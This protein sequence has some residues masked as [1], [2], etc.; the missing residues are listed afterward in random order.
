MK[1][2]EKIL[3]AIFK[4]PTGMGAADLIIEFFKGKAIHVP[5]IG[6]YVYSGTHWIPD[7]AEVEI[8]DLYRE[9]LYYV[10][11]SDD[12]KTFYEKKLDKI[13][14]EDKRKACEK[15]ITTFIRS[16]GNVTFKDKVLSQVAKDRR[17]HCDASKLNPARNVLYFKNG[18]LD[19]NTKKLSVHRSENYNTYVYDW[20]Y[21]SNATCPTFLNA[22][23][24]M[25]FDD[26]DPEQG[27][28]ELQAYLREMIGF[29]LLRKKPDQKAFFWDGR[30]GNGKSELVRVLQKVAGENAAL[31]QISLFT[32]VE[33]RNSNS[34]QSHL[35]PLMGKSVVIA[36]EGDDGGQLNDGIFKQIT[37][38]D[39]I[40]A[41]AAYSAKTVN[42]RPE[43]AAVIATNAL[44]T[45]NGEDEA[46]RRRV[47]RIN[48]P[49][50]FVHEN[51][52]EEKKKTHRF[53]KVKK[54]NIRKDLEDELPGIMAWAIEGAHRVLHNHGISEPAI[55]R[56]WTD[57]YFGDEDPVGAFIENQLDIDVPEYL[58][59]K[60]S[61]V[62]EAF[63]K[64]YPESGFAKR[65]TEKRFHQVLKKA[66]FDRRA[67][68]SGRILYKGLTLK[69][70]QKKQAVLD[71]R[72]R[73]TDRLSIDERIIKIEQ[74]AQT[75]CGNKVSVLKWINSPQPELGGSSPQEA[76]QDQKLFE[77]LLVA[78]APHSTSFAT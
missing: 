34:H 69:D 29:C 36:A 39:Q 54:A 70:T 63:S 50:R 11:L 43:L 40:S 47:H 32:G 4:D 75:V 73:N 21:D 20:D 67:N 65:V 49:C 53:V 26:R 7:I 2:Y 58:T 15:T 16:L 3:N 78:F 59:M 33:A 51:E 57:Q 74:I 17:I 77:K 60:A 68:H 19:L 18:V 37:G 46:I 13:E 25:V 55:I 62:Y 41:R 42:F 14:E 28:D 44:P 64:W 12:F 24:D 71:I 76:I 9:A 27:K 56:Y 23:S 66:L 38:G 45:I 35:I 8:Y 61:E 5:G 1:T 10:V 52:L 48:F 22:L 72:N 6:W 31:V 30:G